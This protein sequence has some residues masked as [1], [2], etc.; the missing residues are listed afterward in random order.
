MIYRSALSVILTVFIGLAL[1]GCGD[2]GGRE[3]SAAQQP[4]QDTPSVVTGHFFSY[5]SDGSHIHAV[6]TTSA[7]VT[8]VATLATPTEDLNYIRLAHQRGRLNGRTIEWSDLLYVDGGKLYLL[9][10]RSETAIAPAPRQL[11]AMADIDTLCGK[12]A[13]ISADGKHEG[14]LFFR[15]DAG[16]GC[17]GG[18]GASYLIT[19]DM[20]PEDAPITGPASW[21]EDMAFSQTQKGIRSI[22]GFIGLRSNKLVML[23][24]A[25]QITAV[26]K[27]NVASINYSVEFATPSDKI[28]IS[29]TT[30]SS[31]SSHHL[32][33]KINNTLMPDLGPEFSFPAFS[34]DQVYGLYTPLIPYASTS[35]AYVA[36]LDGSPVREI[37]C[38]Y[39]SASPLVVIGDLML[40]YTSS[41]VQTLNLKTCEE[42]T[43]INNISGNSYQLFI[44]DNNVAFF[45]DPDQPLIHRLNIVSLDDSPV[46]QA[47]ISGA[48]YTPEGNALS[49][50]KGFILL[51]NLDKNDGGSLRLESY[52]PQGT[53][54]VLGEL[55]SSIAQAVPHFWHHEGHE[56]ALGTL[57][58]TDADEQLHHRLY[59]IKPDEVG[60]LT[61]VMEKD[62]LQKL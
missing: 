62:F 15:P 17:Y 31:Q 41:T 46:A 22:T 18:T 40:A 52:S 61:L 5:V 36:G 32:L 11:S 8:E 35:K 53:R 56:V 58:F 43:L 25:H 1:N 50:L 13:S 29:L 30:T 45:N 19:T 9:P 42:K 57:S 16:E 20:G 24:T 6:N 26:L 55:E 59:S 2:G 60:S 39:S 33:N 12:K 48:I 23:N 47:R 7:E 28:F 44:D 49:K 54:V 4:G 21:Q 3:S 51:S 34:N 38:T 27:E 14:L 10:A 37:A